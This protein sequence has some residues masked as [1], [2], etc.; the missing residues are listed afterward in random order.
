M[1]EDRQGLHAVQTSQTQDVEQDLRKRLKEF[2]CLYEISRLVEAHGDSL[3]KILLGIVDLIP[4]SW[5]HP[6]VC[7]ARL[8]V[9][10]ELFTTSECCQ[11]T[12]VQRADIY[13][14]GLPIGALEVCYGPEIS[15]QDEGPFFKEEHYLLE[16]IAE[17]TGKIIE[18]IRTKNQLD[19][20]RKELRDANTALRMVLSQ[21]EEEKKDWSNSML[22]NVNK[23]IMPMLRDLENQIPAHLRWHIAL[24]KQQLD[25]L[26]SPFVNRLSKTYATLTPAEIEIC[27]MIR[28]GLATK[29]IARFRSVSPATIA[30]QRERI[31]KK[32]QVSGTATNLGTHLRMLEA[33]IS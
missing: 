16:L 29:E 4:P 24:L 11:S 15:R 12:R 26:T 5:Q 22:A 9:E 32:L 10:D 27:N 28:D 1:L 33:G 21:I 31:R 17:R 25:D 30:K 2:D 14:R 19:K 8:T 7:C 18:R 23:I 3:T 6:D 13:V 20:E